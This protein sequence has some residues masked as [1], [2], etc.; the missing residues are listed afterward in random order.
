[1]SD[2]IS[3][4]EKLCN[5]LETKYFLIGM[6]HPGGKMSDIGLTNNKKTRGLAISALILGIVAFVLALTPVV[7]LLLGLAGVGLGIAALIKKQPKGFSITGLALSSVAVV[8]SLITSLVFA[9]FL[10]E[11]TDQ[12]QVTQPSSQAPVEEEPEP[13]PEAFVPDLST[14]T[15]LDERTLALIA[16]DPEA[17]VGTNA[18]VYGEVTQYDSFTG[19]CGMRL[20][21]SHTAKEYTYDYE[22]NTIA[23][24]GDGYENCP[25][26]DPVVQDDVVKLWVTVLGVSEYDTTIG[27]TAT[28]IAIEVWQAEI[29]PKPEY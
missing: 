8:I 23:T 17:Y 4:V 18:I 15:E 13:E 11:G 21:I 10:S 27:G 3:L 14:F 5:S 7:G 20:N 2:E 29:L 12:S 16:K 19:K 24:S 9:V 25:V 1:M 6:N 26:L 22:H 28:A